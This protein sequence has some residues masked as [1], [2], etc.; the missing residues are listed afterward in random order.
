MKMSEIKIPTV[1]WTNNKNSILRRED[2]VRDSTTRADFLNAMALSAKFVMEKKGR[3]D[4]LKNTV[5]KLSLTKE[6][7]DKLNEIIN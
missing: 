1:L 6:E 5:S 2:P 4:H 7:A 3:V